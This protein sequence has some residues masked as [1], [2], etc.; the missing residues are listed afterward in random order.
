MTHP[1]VGR[2]APAFALTDQ[3][4]RKVSLAELRGKAVLLVFVPFAFSDT[5]TNE[6][7][8]LRDAPDLAARD[9]LQVVVVSCDSIY[10][11][12][13]WADTHRYRGTIL[14]DFWPHGDASR[15]Y[16]VFNAQKGLATRGTFLID[17]D[18]VVRWAVV[19]P[20]GEARDV[21]DYRREV[22]ALLG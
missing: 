8:D 2:P 17:A 6:L 20:T 15:D 14:S 18:G 11:L 7:V 4:G 21:D 10:V 12:K 22:A 13:A 16:G 5:C 9:D 19:N 1:L 3:N